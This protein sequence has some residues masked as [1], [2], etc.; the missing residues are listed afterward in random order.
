VAGL[1]PEQE[2]LLRTLVEAARRVPRP[3]Q[4]FMHVSLPTDQQIGTIDYVIGDPIE[5]QLSVLGQ[6]VAELNGQ[7]FIRY[8]SHAWGDASIP[9]TITA[10]GFHAYEELRGR[11]AEVGVAIED[12]VRQ[13]LDTGVRARYPAAYERLQSAEQLLWQADPA[14][15]FTTIGHKLR[16][17]VQQ[18]ATAMIERHQPPEFDPDPAKTKNRL[19]AVIE[20]RRTALGGSK[21]ELLDALV[22]YQDAVNGLIQRQEHGD[23]KPGEPLTW[24]D[25]RAAVFQTTLLL[26]EF[27]RLLG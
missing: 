26:H 8:G 21:A 5:G 12:E 11:S 3:Q 14:P 7:G 15:E 10:N 18:F 2:E 24:E 13:H 1:L 25:A 23:Q 16:E 4:Q 6:D 19:R 20:L 22:V 17:A 27:D 9:F